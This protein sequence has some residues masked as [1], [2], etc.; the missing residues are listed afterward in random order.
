MKVNSYISAFLKRLVESRDFPRDLDGRCET[1]DVVRRRI[2]LPTI[3]HAAIL[4]ALD[5]RQHFLFR[6]EFVTND[7]IRSYNR[8]SLEDLQAQGYLLG[9]VVSPNVAPATV[10]RVASIPRGEQLTTLSPEQSGAVFVFQ[11]EGLSTEDILSELRKNRQIFVKTLGMNPMELQD[12]LK[13]IEIDNASHEFTFHKPTNKDARF[14]PYFRYDPDHESRGQT[15]DL[16]SG[17]TN[18]F[19][20]YVMKDFDLSSDPLRA[21][22]TVESI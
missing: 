17:S 13:L 12:D 4:E 19:N 18:G 11:A 14:R 21:L 6:G 15:L 9:G 2:Y 10:Y 5:V 20:E 22:L 8:T 1:S 16:N 7:G 3:E